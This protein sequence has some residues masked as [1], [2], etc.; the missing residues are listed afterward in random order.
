MQRYASHS[1]TRLTDASI[2]DFLAALCKLVTDS[3]FG[4]KLDNNLCDRLVCGVNNPTK[5]G[6]LLSE[7]FLHLQR[8]VEIAMAADV[9]NCHV[10]QLLTNGANFRISQENTRS[11]RVQ[12]PRITV[13]RE[14]ASRLVSGPFQG[15]I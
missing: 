3:N 14:K 7:P 12:D 4:D 6:L 15:P 11:A 13:S 5:L 9:T 1:W 8:A 10:G 2:A